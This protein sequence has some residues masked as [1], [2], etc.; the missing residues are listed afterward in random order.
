MF[1]GGAYVWGIAGDVAYIGLTGKQRGQEVGGF[2]M[3]NKRLL[4]GGGGGGGGGGAYV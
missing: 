3:G 1:G 4:N 2:C